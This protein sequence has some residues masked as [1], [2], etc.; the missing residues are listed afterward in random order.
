MPTDAEIARSEIFSDL[1]TERTSS[2]I[3]VGDSYDPPLLTDKQ[4]ESNVRLII[5]P[6]HYDNTYKLEPN[7]DGTI[8]IRLG[9]VY[10]IKGQ[11]F[12]T[13]EEIND[14]LINLM[15]YAIATYDPVWKGSPDVR[16][17]PFDCDYE[18][19]RGQLE[20]GDLK[21]MLD[22]ITEIITTKFGFVQERLVKFVIVLVS[23]LKSVNQQRKDDF[24]KQLI[25][26]VTL[27]NLIKN[28][29]SLLDHLHNDQ[30][31]ASMPAVME[32]LAISFRDF[33]DRNP[34]NSIPLVVDEFISEIT[35][36]FKWI[37]IR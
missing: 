30:P 3:T 7:S 23:H 35:R 10:I 4:R 33:F 31:F 24:I 20:R 18:R 2:L 6:I 26:N 12:T 15:T 19:L 9:R 1:K 29:S 27:E 21:P 25:A 16:K 32:G 36:R 34:D 8:D 28:P 17:N 22:G 37:K 11:P 14:A 13:Q 5:F